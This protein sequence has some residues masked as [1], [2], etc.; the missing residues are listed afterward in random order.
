MR[1]MFRLKA[2]GSG[3]A[4]RAATGFIQFHA[5]DHSTACAQKIKRHGDHRA[6]L[7]LQHRIEQFAL[8]RIL[9][10]FVL[11]K[12]LLTGEHHANQPGL[13]RLLEFADQLVSVWAA[14]PGGDE[15]FT[16]L[17]EQPDGAFIRAGFGEA[18]LERLAHEG[19]EQ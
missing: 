11:Q 16:R 19:I 13:Q 15:M 4:A 12:W 14:I 9:P 18:V 5:R 3:S 8:A 7:D 2:I 10:D 17:I 1:Q 6:G